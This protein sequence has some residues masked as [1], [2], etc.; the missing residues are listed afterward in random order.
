MRACVGLVFSM[1]FNLGN[2]VVEVFKIYYALLLIAEFLELARRMPAFG[3][4]SDLS[5]SSER[6][7]MPSNCMRSSS[8][9]FL[10]CFSR[11]F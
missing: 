6:G 11:T 5:F 3:G 2:E 9:M 8:A 4:L 10:V 1:F 7:D